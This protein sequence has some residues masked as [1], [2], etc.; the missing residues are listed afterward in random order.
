MRALVIGGGI[1]GL[2][3][4]SALAERGHAVTLLEAEPALGTHSSARNAQIWLPVDDDATT[5]PLARR[6][7]ARMTALLGEEAAWLRRT[8][9]L[10]LVR[11]ETEA[12]AMARGAARGGVEARPIPMAE[13]RARCPALGPLEDEALE[14]IG[15]GVLDPHAMLEALARRARAGGATLRTGARVQEVCLHPRREARLSGGE[16]VAFDALVIAAGAWAGALGAGLGLD[17]HLVP[18]R[19]HLAVLEA[20]PAEAGTIV[21]RFGDESVYWRPESGGVLVSPCDEVALAPCLPAPADDVAERLVAALRPAAPRW[22]DAP[23]RTAWAC[24]RTYAH[25][26]ELVLGPDPRLDGVAWVAGLGGRGMTVG[27][28]AGELC[29]RALAGE[30]LDDE[31]AALLARARPDRAQPS[32]LCEP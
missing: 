26:R 27:V 25:D 13:A 9:A 24:L 17:A 20:S 2:S 18:L 19:R 15:A 8:G 16:R 31:S 28:A 14:V 21:W 22:I 12:A 29:A 4:A 30:P 5:G 7:A 1:A 10:A 32:G 3:V 11:G 6:S 23:L